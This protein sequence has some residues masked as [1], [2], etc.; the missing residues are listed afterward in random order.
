V[1][2]LAITNLDRLV[3]LP[4]VKVATRYHGGDERFFD[5]SGEFRLP[6]DSELSW[7]AART[8]AMKAISPAFAHLQLSS[9]SGGYQRFCEA[10]ADQL[11]HPIAA[12]ST[13]ASDRKLYLGT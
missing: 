5:A 13:T 2:T 1:D 11:G 12:C 6:P 3:H 9:D 10:L 4:K 7:L 8:E